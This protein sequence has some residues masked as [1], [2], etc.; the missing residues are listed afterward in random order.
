MKS[1]KKLT[2]GRKQS[3]LNLLLK[4]SSGWR[5]KKLLVESGSGSSLEI[6][7]YKVEDLFVI[8]TVDITKDIKYMQVLKIWDVLRPNDVPKL[9]K[10][11]D[12]IFGKYTADFVSLCNDK[13]FD[14]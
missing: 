12:N 3:I 1:F 2:S 6:R 13:S 4:L 7:K 5:P 14:G 8:S 11:L 10:H 9:I